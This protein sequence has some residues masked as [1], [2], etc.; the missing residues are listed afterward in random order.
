MSHQPVR[1]RTAAFSRRRGRRVS[2]L[3]L[4]AVAMTVPIAGCS[5]QDAICGG[6]EYP[7]LNVG[8][9]GRAC[10]P[11]GEEP[12]KGYVR[13]PEGKVP[14]HV[15]DEWDEYWQSHTVDKDGKTV[16]VPEEAPQESPKE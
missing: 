10:V 15:G 11:N 16:T 2:A 5:I 13:F 4:A 8:S 12:P 7:V 6:G 9:T 3:V 14:E 1:T